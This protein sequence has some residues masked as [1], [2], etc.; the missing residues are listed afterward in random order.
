[1]VIGGC[2]TAARSLITYVTVLCSHLLGKKLLK[3][4]QQIFFML[5]CLFLVRTVKL[6]QLR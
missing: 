3:S 2:E 6:E 4:E 5:R 1:M